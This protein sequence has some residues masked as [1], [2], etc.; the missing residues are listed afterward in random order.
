[1]GYSLKSMRGKKKGLSIPIRTRVFTIGS[2]PKNQVR[3]RRAGVGR[4]HCALVIRKKKLYLQD[5]QSGHPTKVN[6]QTMTPGARLVL[7]IGDRV[8]M[9]PMEFVIEL[10]Q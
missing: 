3:S 4:R 8:S 5:L 7:N 9:G 1:M 6:G 10:R 2:S